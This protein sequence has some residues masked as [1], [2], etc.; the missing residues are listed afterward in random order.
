MSAPNRDAAG[1][2]A[3]RNTHAACRSIN[4]WAFDSLGETRWAWSCDGSSDEATYPTAAAAL[5]VVV[6]AH[7]ARST[8]E[9]A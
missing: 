3:M 2:Q 1:R 7:A 9:D 5:E 4:L 6:A 8:E